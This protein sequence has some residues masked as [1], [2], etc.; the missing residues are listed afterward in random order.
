MNKHILLVMK[1]LNDKDSVTQK[2]LKENRDAAAD[3]Y[4]AADAAYTAYTS[5][6][7]EER[8]NK[9]F[10]RTGEDKQKY[11]DALGSTGLPEPTEYIITKTKEHKSSVACDNGLWL[12]PVEPPIELID[13]ECY[14]FT[15][16]SGKVRKGYF[17]P[18]K[19]LFVCAN[20]NVDIDM[21]TNIKHLTADE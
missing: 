7:T 14:Q 1:W 17:I 10:E 6:Y 19:K 20:G 21:C 11:I 9:Y 15:S 8:V 16:P 13:G 5:A 18:V 3:A 4:A 12:T 2:E